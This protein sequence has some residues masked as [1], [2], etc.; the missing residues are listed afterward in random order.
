LNT[1]LMNFNLSPKIKLYV[2]AEMA[3]LL[4]MDEKELADAQEERKDEEGQMQPPV[5]GQTPQ[6]QD[7]NKNQGDPSAQDQEEE[8]VHE[9]AHSHVQENFG[10]DFSLKEWLGFN[11]EDFKDAIRKFIRQYGFSDL[12]AQTDEEV[13]AGKFSSKQISK[14]RGILDTAFERGLSIKQI[15]AMVKTEVRPGNLYD[16]KDGKILKQDGKKVL[17]VSKSVRPIL[18]ARTE[19]TRA[20]AE[21][22]INHYESGGVEKVRYLAALSSRTCDLCESLNGRVFTIEESRGIIPTKTHVNCRCTWVPV[23]EEAQ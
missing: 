15:E 7:K 3:R 16:M 11:Y 9:K 19:S 12:I 2:E 21:G 22:A 17:L 14:L 13:K 10:Q 5:P 8:H 4:G 20:A 23:I 18:I 6:P 1:I